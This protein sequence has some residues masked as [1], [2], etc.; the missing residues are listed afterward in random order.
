MKFLLDTGGGLTVLSNKVFQRFKSTMKNAGF[1]TGFRHN[2]ERLDIELFSLPSISIGHHKVSNVKSG[3]YAP[4]DDYGIDGIISAKEFENQPFTINY[5]NNTVTIEDKSSLAV[6]E[7]SAES[8]PITLHSQMDISL[9]IFVPLCLNDS[10]K[11]QAEFDTGSGH[12]LFLINPYF[13][14]KL[15]I[16]SSSV[17]KGTEPVANTNR[18]LNLYF[19]MLPSY[20]YSCSPDLEAKNSN[21]TFKEDLIYEGLIGSAMF[22]DKI[23]TIDIPNKRLLVRK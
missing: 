5:Q 1:F 16:D 9:D 20:R 11:I 22:K 8:I 15:G 18:T 12:N 17:S 14:N 10:I 19:V 6:I 4:L 23:L 21:V 7:S 13:M 3:V 2:G